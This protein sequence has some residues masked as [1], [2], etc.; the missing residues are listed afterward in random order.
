[1]RQNALVVG[2]LFVFTAAAGTGC[3]DSNGAGAIA[4]GPVYAKHVIEIDIDD[5]GL[6]GLEM[7]NAPNLKGL[8]ARGTLAY[9]R[10]IIPTHSN[11][12]NMALITGQYPDGNNVPA[13]AWLGRDIN[14]VPPVNLPGLASG[15]Y[16]R[17]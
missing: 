12:S 16:T 5:H 13:N 4:S 11:Q 14:F 3:K 8:I 15:D 10:V 7:A 2:I 9:T 1:M 17:Y 6:A